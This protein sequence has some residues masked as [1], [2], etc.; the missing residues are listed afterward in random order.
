MNKN[1]IFMISMIAVSVL[2]F[3]LRMTGLGA[4]IAV[5]VLG[6][7]VMIPFTVKTRKEWTKPALEVLMRVMYLVAIVTGGLLMKMHGIAALGVVH[8]I[9]A[10]L[11]VVL[12]LAL[13]SCTCLVLH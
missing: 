13:F 12:L 4:H 5:S 7:A 11:F 6:L 1:G 10:V 2:L 9:G 8:K 3:L